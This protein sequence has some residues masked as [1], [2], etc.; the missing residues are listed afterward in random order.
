MDHVNYNSYPSDLRITDMRF[1]DIDQAPM[2]CILLK[3][4]TNQGITGMGEVRDFA[5][6]KYALMLKNILIGEN[7]CNVDKIF[8]K[9][10][11]FGGHSRFGGGVSGVEVALWDI[12]GKAYNVPIYQMLGGKFRS[13]VRMYCDTDV[14][15]KNTGAKMGAA[16]KARM[17]KGFTLLK[18]DFGM[19]LLYDVPNA[20][21]APADFLPKL[22]NASYQDLMFRNGDIKE[23]IAKR[24]GSDAM[25]V[26]HH[27]TMVQI[28]PRGYEYLEQYFTEVRSVIG[29]EIPVA[30]DHIGHIGVSECIKLGKLLEKFNVAWIE[31]AV[32]WQFT[33]QYVRLQNAVN[34]PVCTGE[35]I[36]LKENF[37]PLL[38]SGGIS[39]VHPDVLTCGGILE[40]KKIGDMA[41]EY[42]VGMA[43]HMAESPVACMAAA[44]AATASENFLA[45]EYHSNDVP[46]WNDLVIGQSPIVENGYISVTDKPGLG[47]DD[48]ND[49]VIAEHLHTHVK[50]VWKETD[51]WNDGFSNNRVWS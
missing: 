45:L 49:D 24:Q 34:V 15:G 41:Q 38:S 14:E 10:K 7:P 31:D 21:C 37:K 18:M 9:I 12:A 1:A 39:V 51:E 30:I 4:Y 23:R 20:L 2:H 29:Y 48:Y 13:K 3:L 40:T 43:I 8:R 17:D 27:N 44:H 36:Y 6:K 35:D 33:N 47:L 11:Q 19:E 46:W 22:A 28:T 42:G 32:P 50:G 25:N 26:M 16:L 5:D